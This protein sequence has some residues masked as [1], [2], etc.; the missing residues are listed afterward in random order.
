MGFVHLDDLFPSLAWWG[1]FSTPAYM[2]HSISSHYLVLPSRPLKQTGENKRQWIMSPFIWL[3]LTL[4]KVDI[5]FQLLPLNERV[6]EVQAG[7]DWA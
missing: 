3:S 5:Q 4:I 6:K 2:A 7:L 1:E